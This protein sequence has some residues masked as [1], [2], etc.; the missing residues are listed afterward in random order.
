MHQVLEL[1]FSCGADPVATS[2]GG[3]IKHSASERSI[4]IYGFSYG[5]PWADDVYRH[6]LSAKLCV[7]AF[8]ESYSVTTS[9]EG[10]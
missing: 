6:D 4:E 1:A 5:F 2:A 7:E 9:D 10:Y 3:R 8:G